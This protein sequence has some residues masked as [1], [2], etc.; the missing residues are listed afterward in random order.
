MSILLREEPSSSNGGDGVED[1]VEVQ[2]G[3]RVATSTDSALSSA[4]GGTSIS[5]N[6]AQARDSKHWLMTPEID[7]YTYEK[8]S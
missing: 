6:I 5:G 2:E 3:E 4:I 7:A 1:G 8:E